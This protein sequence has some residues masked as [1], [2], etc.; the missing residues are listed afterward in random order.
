MKLK[1]AL[2]F[3]V[4]PVLLTAIFLEPSSENYSGIY[5][6][7]LAVI[8]LALAACF[9]RPV[10]G[11][12][13]LVMSMHWIMEE[14]I[15]LSLY[16]LMI[17]NLL[18]LLLGLVKSEVKVDFLWFTP[19][20]IMLAYLGLVLLK[21]PYDLHMTIYYVD[22]VGLVFF[23]AVSLFRWDSDRV[24]NF[25]SAHLTYM[26]VWALIER[27]VVYSDRISGPSLSATNFAA[28]VTTSWTIWMINGWISGKTRLPVLALG[29]AA[30]CLCVILSGSRM[31]FIGMGIGGMFGILSFFLK[32]MKSRILPI[33][34]KVLLV[35]AVL[36]ALAVLLWMILPDES[37]IKRGFNIL[38]KGKLDRSSIGRLGVWLTALDIFKKHPMWGCG[39]GN[40]LH[41]NRLFL[42][43][44]NMIPLMRYVPRLGHAHNVYLMVLSEQGIVGI[45]ALGSVCLLCFRELFL[46][47]KNK[48]DGLGFALL[49]GALVFMALGL[50]DV[51]PLFPSSL[52]WGAWYMGVLF[53]LRLYRKGPK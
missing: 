17:A 50:I 35:G 27:M 47:I 31:G 13:C 42:D 6:L 2:L 12:C 11:A 1:G 22:L 29:S 37:L 19:L 10:I 34:G 32:D 40:F 30:V 7:A 26:V 43:Q 14:G 8:G 44:F 21:K 41:F 45:A 24:H 25:L 46:Y 5:A 28:M 53:S 9:S 4:L 3:I 48:W 38:A 49:G 51:F 20:G 39:P 16:F 15:Y 33:L 18:F 52:G 36:A 23:A